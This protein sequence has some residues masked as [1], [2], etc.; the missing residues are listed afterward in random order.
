MK[1]MRQQQLALTRPALQRKDLKV[2]NAV[3]QHLYYLRNRWDDEAE[4]EDFSDYVKSAREAIEQAGGTF[5]SLT[6][7][8]FRATFAL[9]K[10]RH[11]LRVLRDRVTLS[12]CV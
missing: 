6:A 3:S 11:E 5:V 10:E 8:P 1:T 4:Y 12:R 9:G 7:S 2:M